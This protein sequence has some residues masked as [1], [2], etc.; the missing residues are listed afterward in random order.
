MTHSISWPIS[1]DM[2][3]D[4]QPNKWNGQRMWR[5]KTKKCECARCSFSWLLGKSEQKTNLWAIANWFAPRYHG[6]SAQCCHFCLLGAPSD[7]S[8]RRNPF[9]ANAYSSLQFTTL[10]SIV[11]FMLVRAFFDSYQLP[12]AGAVI[13]QLIGSKSFSSS[14]DFTSF[15]VTLHS[16]SA[17]SSSS[18]RQ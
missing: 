5:S 8:Q 11:I 4:L 18:K 12:D 7:A 17:A 14:S 10:F 9:V 16:D 3:C 2:G 6:S 1:T 13:S 15:L